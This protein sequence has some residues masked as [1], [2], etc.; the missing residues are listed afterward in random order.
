[1]SVLRKRQ[2][3]GFRKHI[4]LSYDWLHIESW[5]W[6]MRPDRVQARSSSALANNYFRSSSSATTNLRWRHSDLI[7]LVGRD[8]HW[9]RQLWRMDW[10]W[11]AWIR[12]VGRRE[13]SSRE[14]GRSC[15][16]CGGHSVH[17]SPARSHYHCC[18]PGENKSYNLI[19]IIASI[20]QNIHPST[21]SEIFVSLVYTKHWEGGGGG[22]KP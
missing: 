5:H 10:A 4:K 7:Q 17:H 8:V 9:W 12:I 1:M 16:W 2:I 21:E 19:I 18:R 6:H 3:T 20:Q 13:R 14:E 15:P 22:R 11:G